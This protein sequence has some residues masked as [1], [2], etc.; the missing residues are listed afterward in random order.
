MVG[1]TG[2]SDLEENLRN[3]RLFRMEC[4]QHTQVSTVS[5]CGLVGWMLHGPE[6]CAVVFYAR[7]KG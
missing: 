7:V 1:P 2:S 5:S 3:L 6:G 4:V